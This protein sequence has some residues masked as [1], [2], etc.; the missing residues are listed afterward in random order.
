MPWYATLEPPGRASFLVGCHD[1]AILF[2]VFASGI[3]RLN[4][5]E[6]SIGGADTFY[7]RGKIANL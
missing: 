5:L 1:C 2:G 3:A 4:Y 7:E 6:W